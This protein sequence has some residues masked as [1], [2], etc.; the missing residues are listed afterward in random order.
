MEV[1]THLR[2]LSPPS[3]LAEIGWDSEFLDFLFFYPLFYLIFLFLWI[4]WK[5]LACPAESVYY[6]QECPGLCMGHMG[7]PLFSGTKTLETYE[8]SNYVYSKPRT[9]KACA[10]S[11][12]KDKTLSPKWMGRKRRRFSSST[13]GPN[14]FAAP[15]LS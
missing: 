8:N 7:N 2:S 12:Y 1:L 11:V 10:R 3:L 4:D 13:T 5:P 14:K 9:R 15:D 6:S